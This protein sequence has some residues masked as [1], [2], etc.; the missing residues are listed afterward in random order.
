MITN[1]RMLKELQ[2][3]LLIFK[4]EIRRDLAAM[5]RTIQRADLGVSVYREVVERQTRENKELH[6]RLM[7]RNLPELKTWNDSPF[8]SYG[9][10]KEPE[11][12]DLAGE[13]IDKLTE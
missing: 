13:I 6:D 2:K 9:G 4:Q 10:N 1:A 8:A 5:E 11:E 7:A 3:S 12:E